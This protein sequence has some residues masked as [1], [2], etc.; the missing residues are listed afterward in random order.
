MSGQGFVL[1]G[2]LV[3]RVLAPLFVVAAAF[4]G[5]T[6]SAQ[7]QKGVVST[8]PAELQTVFQTI[9]SAGPLN[10]I[11]IGE[12]LSAQIAH[13][14]DT[15]EEIYPPGTHPGDY[16]TFLLINGTLYSSDFQN[17]GGTASSGIGVY[18]A[19]TPVSQSAVTGAG[20]SGS[21]FAVT[22]VVT[23]GATGLSVTQVDSYVVGQE[24]YRTDV[25]VTNTGNAAVS[26]T[27]FRAFDCYLG[28]S[29]SGYGMVTGTGPG[30]SQNPSNVPA[31]RIEQIVPLNGGNDYYESGYGAVWAWIGT[32]APFPNT[33][34]CTT[35][36]DNGSGISWDITVPPGGSLT[37]S[38]LTVFSPLGTQPL[39]T[40]KTADAASATAGGADGYTITI[41]NPNT[42]AATLNSITDTL[43]TGFT[44]TPGSSTGATTADPTIAASTLTWAGPIAVPPGGTAALHF[45]VTVSSTAGT[46]TNQATADAG[47]DTVVG[48]GPTAPITVGGGGGGGGP[49]AAIP[50]PTL[51]EGMLAALVLILL[52]AGV[53]AG[54]RARR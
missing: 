45:G 49:P 51:S 6:V 14:G 13:V 24:S 42:A 18:T 20:T 38:N 21:P 22:T 31:G 9:S 26:A 15:S 25:T 54:R 32:H 28:G 39:F 46:Y 30:C 1:N 2:A 37:R 33:C 50:A 47:A 8:V 17:H 12:D 53:F 3:R 29:D 40:T 36:E 10:A 48:T 7:T 44:Y 41:S 11:Y 35:L 5:S 52:A 27:M 4:G 19:F 43:P 23:V 16:G 34:D